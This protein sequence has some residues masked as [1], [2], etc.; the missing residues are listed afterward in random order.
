VNARHLEATPIKPSFV[1]FIRAGE[2]I[3]IGRT[4]NIYNRFAT[5]AR[6]VPDKCVLVAIM[7]GSAG[8]ERALHTRF[9]HLR[10]NG[11]W[12]RA[13]GDLLSFIAEIGDEIPTP[14]LETSQRVLDNH[15]QHEVEPEYDPE[16]CTA[17]AAAHEL[18]VYLK[19]IYRWLDNRTLAEV[20]VIG[21]ARIIYA[22]SVAALKRER[23]RANA[24]KL[25]VTMTAYHVTPEELAAEFPS[26]L[27]GQAALTDDQLLECVT[28]V[29]RIMKRRNVAADTTA[30]AEV[31]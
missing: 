12:F 28:A 15:V 31:G 20:T 21:N 18:G 22:D 25:T 27:A 2:H 14:A 6:E 7:P 11:E 29:K 30:M 13:D 16:Y 19:Q 3:K 5:I 10:A 4:S 17:A 1:Y 24:N 23:E 26:A 8:Q 9:S